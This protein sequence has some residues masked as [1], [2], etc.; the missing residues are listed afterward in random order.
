MGE[1]AEEPDEEQL[2]TLWVGS[3]SEK[4]QSIP[5]SVGDPD[6]VE[7]GT[8]FRIRNSFPVPEFFFQIWQ[9]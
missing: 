9:E 8:L 3:I 1:K 4:V 2:R 6:P 7:S 5:A